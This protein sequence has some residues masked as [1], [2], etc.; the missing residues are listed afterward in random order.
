MLDGICSFGGGTDGFHGFGTGITYPMVVN[1]QSQLHAAAVGNILEGFG[2]LKGKE[3]TYTY[4]GCISVHQGFS[5]N[6]MCRVMDPGGGLRTEAILPALERLPNPEQAVTYIV[7]RGQKKD[8]N[9]QTTYS[10]GSDGQVTGLNVVQQLRLFHLDA[11]TRGRGGLRSTA[12]M[13]QVIGEMTAKIAFNLF[14]PGAPGTALSP[15]PFKS[16]NEY[17]FFDQYGESLGGFAAD[18]A[19][20]R[21]FNMKLTGAPGQATLRFGG[22]GPILNGTGRFSGIQGLMTDNSVVG[23]A[24]HALATLYVLRINDPDGKYREAINVK[25]HS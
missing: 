14:D 21:T 16:Y 23:I 2:K 13:G 10:F 3:G 18:G 5:G 11:T 12:A 7:F 6:L 19:E 24:P 4:C 8:K 22:V 1:G 20:G 15:I 25:N 9:Q 17:R